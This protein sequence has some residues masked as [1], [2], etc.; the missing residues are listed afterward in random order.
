M[1]Y[2]E[3]EKQGLALPVAEAH[4]EYKQPATYDDTLQI[5]GQVAWI[6]GARLQIN[7]EVYR[8]DTLLAKGYTVHACIDINTRRVVRVPEELIR[9]AGLAD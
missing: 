7:C 6:K 4:V 5:H 2:K 1:P 9:R 8:G 3:M